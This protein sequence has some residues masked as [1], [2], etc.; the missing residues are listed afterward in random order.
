MTTLLWAALVTLKTSLAQCC[1]CSHLGR[2]LSMAW[3]SR[4]MAG[5]RRLAG[6]E[7]ISESANQRISESAN[8]QRGEGRNC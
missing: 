7:R 2:P 5:F 8:Q 4:W 3:W 1:G 6:Y